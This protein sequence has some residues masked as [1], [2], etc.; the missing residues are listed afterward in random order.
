MKTTLIIAFAVLGIMS[1]CDK[2]DD[3]DNNGVTSQDREFTMR[4]S[5][6]NFAETD[7]GQLAA[8][9]ATNTG[10]KEFGAHMVADHTTANQELKTLANQLGLHAPDSLDAEHQ[11]LKTKLMSL[12]GRAFDSVYIH[13]QLKDH[14][15]AISLFENQANTGNNSRLREYANKQL[16]HLRMHLQKADSLVN[17]F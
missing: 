6:A 12:S 15:M 16:P 5:M 2:D 14:N 1:S 13:S 17:N 8:N 4:A 9:K 11:Q 7:A 3:D 10:I